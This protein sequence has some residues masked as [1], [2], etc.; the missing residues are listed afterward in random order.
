MAAGQSRWIKSPVCGIEALSL[1][2]EQPI[3]GNRAAHGDQGQAGFAGGGCGAVVLGELHHLL[4][5]RRDHSGSTARVPAALFVAVGDG[6][7]AGEPAAS[8][9]G[10]RPPLLHAALED[11]HLDAGETAL[12]E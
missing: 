4:E 10:L 6:R 2:E 9:E 5:G 3:V 8:A 1:I 12:H 7:V 11:A